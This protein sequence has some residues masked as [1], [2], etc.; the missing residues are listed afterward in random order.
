[1]RT[2]PNSPETAVVLDVDEPLLWDRRGWKRYCLK[3]KKVSEIF[4]IPG[5]NL[6]RFLIWPS[7]KLLP[8]SSIRVGLP[9]HIDPKRTSKR[10]ADALGGGI[11]GC[12]S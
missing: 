8:R 7:D 12:R 6:E 5:V 3:K 10:P 9:E 4:K 2:G 1:M 11:R